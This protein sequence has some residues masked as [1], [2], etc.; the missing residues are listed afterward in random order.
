[1]K[2]HEFSKEYEEKKAVL[3]RGV[4]IAENFFE[5]KRVAF[6]AKALA[7]VAL[8][9]MLTVTAYAAV[10][11]GVFRIL[12]EDD[13]T[14]V[15]LGEVSDYP[16]NTDP[17]EQSITVFSTFDERGEIPQLVF[18]RNYMPDMIADAKTGNE[19]KFGDFDTGTTLSFS[20]VY[21]GG[22]GFTYDLGAESEI[23]EF[24]VN[25]HSAMII[26]R[27]ETAYYNKILSV[28]F[29][30]KDIL[31]N[32]FAGYGVPRDELKSI[33]SGF[34]FEE[35][36]D[37]AKAYQIVHNHGKL[38]LA[39][40]LPDMGSYNPLLLS[41]NISLGD[42]ITH[43][44]RMFSLADET[45]TFISE[46]EIVPVEIRVADSLSELDAD[47]IV[48]DNFK[49]FVGE[50]GEFIA[51]P[52]TEILRGTVP[53]DADRFGITENVKKKL[54]LVTFNIKNTSDKDGA[55]YTPGNFLLHVGSEESVI[56][57]YVYD[58]IP[59]KY[60]TKETPVYYDGGGVGRSYFRTEFAAGEEKICKVG[61]LVDEDM[62][63]EA[64]LLFRIDGEVKYNLSLIE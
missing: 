6:P 30:D 52:R 51:Y 22:D 35:T 17:M 58:K 8:C 61:F 18:N 33:A 53:V 40:S 4:E 60:S 34:S 39:E 49:G 10:E 62:L 19:I 29:E 47:Y 25:G 11:L 41:E 1:M 43:N 7:A 38:T 50:D 36:S 24:E 44:D 45:D 5:R 48:Y 12:H 56:S 26:T 32:C 23:E 2:E 16:D 63:D 42:T 31:V 57:D 27:G 64:Y 21:L 59:Q 15:Q 55:S 46:L 14:V 3:M 9:I 54:V 13:K 37:S 28:Y 20:V